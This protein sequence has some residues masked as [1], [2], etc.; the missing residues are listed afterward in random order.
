MFNYIVTEDV[1]WANDE[2]FTSGI[3]PTIVEVKELSG[4]VIAD[5][6]YLFIGGK[7]G[8]IF[9]DGIMYNDPSEVGEE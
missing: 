1:V 6:H 5:N 4:E 2:D 7:L 9:I 8:K 3:Y